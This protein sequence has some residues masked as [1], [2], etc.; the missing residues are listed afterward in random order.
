MKILTIVLL[1][2]SLAPTFR[3]DRPEFVFKL[4]SGNGSTVLLQ[5][6]L[7]TQLKMTRIEG[8]DP[9]TTIFQCTVLDRKQA[10]LTLHLLKCGSGVYSLDAVL[11]SH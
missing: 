8:E 10:D 9:S 5:P 4:V 6:V 1:S 11:F 3:A 7:P 2:L